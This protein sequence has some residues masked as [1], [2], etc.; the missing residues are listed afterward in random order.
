MSASLALTWRRAWNGDEIS[1]LIG[2]RHLAAALRLHREVERIG[3]LRAVRS[4]VNEELAESK[5]GYEYLG[6]ADVVS[7]IDRAQRILHEGE[8]ME[9]FIKSLDADYRDMLKDDRLFANFR[10]CYRMR[11]NEFSPVL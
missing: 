6:L 4:S 10:I 7:I 2:N 9:R 11:P 3:L 1:A 5:L 8:N